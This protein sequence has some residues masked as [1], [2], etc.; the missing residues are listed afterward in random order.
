MGRSKRTTEFL[1]ECMADALIRLLR[2]KS[3]EKITVDEITSE[4]GVGR[5]TWFRNFSGKNEA[6]TYKLIT[7][8]ERWAAEHHLVERHRFDLS[9]AAAFF[10]FN[11]SISPMLSAI[12]R[13][14]LGACVYDA[15][16][17]CMKAQNSAD[18]QECYQSG[19]YLHA[20][21]GL[22]NEWILRDF[23]ESP[24]EMKEILCKIIQMPE[25]TML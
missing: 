5:A 20:L 17:G 23:C 19:F 12:Y 13:A 14:D 7:S 3:M 2:T 18:K 4:A 24:E 6:V 16:I 8:W 15:F 25:D 21:F 10:E 1:K 9:N 22:L 11:Q